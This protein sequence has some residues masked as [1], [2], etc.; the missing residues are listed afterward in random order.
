MIPV[1]RRSSLRVSVALLLLFAG[2][3]ALAQSSACNRAQAIVE[4]VKALYE[5]GRPDHQAILAKLK[6]A[7]QLCPTLGEAWKYAHCSAV[8]LGDSAS[9][10]RFK[11]RAVFN[12]ASDLNCGAGST[13]APTPLPSYVR[14]KFALVIGIGNFRDPAIPKLKFAAKDARDFAR[15]LTEQRYGNFPPENVKLLTDEHATREAI[16]NGVQELILR[17]KPEDLVVVY[18]SSHGSPSKQDTGLGGIGYIVTYDTKLQNIWVDSIEYQDFAEK[19]ALIPARRKVAFLDTCFSGQASRAGAK[20]LSVG[21]D[22]RTAKMFLSGEGTFVITSSKFDERS[23]ES[24]S[25][26]NSYFTYYLIEAL[27]VSKEQPPTIKDIFQSLS[28]RVS[29]A[30][31]KEKNQP[32]HP[33]IHPTDGTG[34]VRIG[35]MPRGESR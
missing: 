17:A 8:A 28:S 14:Q 25:I 18:V 34:D 29:G 32:Q 10:E 16:L 2:V 1:S 35:V 33:Q 27:K 20:L 26:Q 15:A 31:A 6:T 13:P 19:T 24:E 12:N 11:T 5:A 7:H 4:E 22:D 3:Q 9:A 23:W 30:V 21:V